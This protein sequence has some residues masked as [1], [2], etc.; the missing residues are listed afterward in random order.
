MR[1]TITVTLW[2][3]GLALDEVDTGTGL[4]RRLSIQRIFISQISEGNIEP[5]T[6]P[7]KYIPSLAA[8]PTF[9]G[10]KM[11]QF[12]TFPGHSANQWQRVHL[13]MKSSRE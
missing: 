10:D 9:F 2:G 13:T 8:S 7:R 5:L 6:P 4:T 3:G 12:A 11:S 1:L